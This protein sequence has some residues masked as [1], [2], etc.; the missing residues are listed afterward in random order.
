MQYSKRSPDE[1]EN[2]DIPSMTLPSLSDILGSA[3]VPELGTLV[4]LSPLPKSATLHIPLRFWWSTRTHFTDVYLAMHLPWPGQYPASTL[5]FNVV[6]NS[7]YS[8]SKFKF[9][10]ARTLNI[11]RPYEDFTLMPQMSLP[12]HAAI[13]LVSVYISGLHIRCGLVYIAWSSSPFSF[14]SCLLEEQNWA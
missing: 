4:K 2:N 9:P 13:C 11:S 6:F 14:L 1:W 3:Q 12:L 8:Y 7:F 10:S 5:E